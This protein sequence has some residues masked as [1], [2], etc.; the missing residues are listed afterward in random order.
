MIHVLIL[1]FLLLVGSALVY[2]GATYLVPFPFNSV[3]YLAYIV[4]VLFGYPLLMF[5]KKDDHS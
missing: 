1:A 3:I 4:L 5:G 2:A